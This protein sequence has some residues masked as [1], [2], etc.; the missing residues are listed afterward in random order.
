MKVFLFTFL[1][2]V[3][4][5]CLNDN[6]ISGISETDYVLGEVTFGLRDSVSLMELADF[7]YVFN[8]ISI[9]NVT[10]F[11]YYTSVSQDSMP[12][13]KSILE[14]KSY[15]RDDA[16]TISYIESNSK[17]LVKFWVIDF[18]TEDRSDWKTTKARFSLVHLPQKFQL[19]L[20]KVET[21]TEKEWIHFLSNTNLFRFVE[22]NT[23]DTIQ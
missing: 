20:L 8:N 18:R 3:M 14:A 15:I 23:I 13:I 21:G 2:A 4:L 7:I 11:Q 19:G 22:L 17:I 1:T 9:K 16:V 10:F 6:S 12:I 5:S